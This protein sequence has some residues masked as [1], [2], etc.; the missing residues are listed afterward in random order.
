MPEHPFAPYVRILGRGKSNSRSLTIDEAETAMA[1]ILGG[2]VLPEQ[3]GAFLMLL[4][5]KEETPEEIAGFVKAAQASII[6][7]D[8]APKV[9]LDW[10]C[11]AGKRRQLPWFALAA[12]ALSQSG[13][14]IF[15]HGI[16]GHTVGR[17]Y[18]E[19]T[20]TT[21]GL[22]IANSL[23]EASEI[24]K[25]SNICYLPLEHISTALSDLIGLKSV[26]GLRS[27]AHTIARMLNPF[28]APHVLQG[29]FHPGFNSVHQK[30]AALIEQPHLSVFRGEGGEIERR[31][32]KPIN[33][34][35]VHNGNLSTEHWPTIMG[36]PHQKT[37]DDMDLG[38]LISVWQGDET[39]PYATAAIK[40]TLAIA[41]TLMGSAQSQS[42]AYKIADEIWDNR[43][44]KYGIKKIK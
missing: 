11:Y 42:E 20:F 32:Q 17:I 12:F 19:Q 4:R 14:K 29:I 36:D 18:A 37:D 31:P 3:I 24:L 10:S 9:D 27:P 25:V 6:Q 40:G 23:L 34:M 35:S 33:V 30:A 26:L 8:D 21:L 22:H 7:P 1:M 39:F 2:K 5:F 41:I 38:R 44:Q 43:D 28:R 15:I 16:E 13:V